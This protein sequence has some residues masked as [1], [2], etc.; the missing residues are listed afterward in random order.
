M[1]VTGERR[2]R[3]REREGGNKMAPD[4]R[5][6]QRI[7][8][9]YRCE[10]GEPGRREGGRETRRLPHPVQVI[11][12]TCFSFCALHNRKIEGVANASAVILC[13]N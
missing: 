6:V 2:G 10:Q 13:I 1:E 4:Q 12:V 11:P 7:G 3:E 5:A 8:A 9:D